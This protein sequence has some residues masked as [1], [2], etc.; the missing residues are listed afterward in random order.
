M[1]SSNDDED[2]D[3]TDNIIDY[4]SN[5]NSNE[6][7]VVRTMARSPFTT[8]SRPCNNHVSYSDDCSAILE[9]Q[10]RTIHIYIYTII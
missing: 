2:D 3:D 8:M 9:H 5:V 1:D 4:N 10:S 7:M 6:T